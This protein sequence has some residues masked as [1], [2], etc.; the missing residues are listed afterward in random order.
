MPE[1]EGVVVVRGGAQGFVQEITAGRHH[2]V[3]DEPV[4]A[5]GTDRGPGPYDLILAALGSCMSM[6]IALY[7]RTKKWPLET[8][9]IRLTHS[10]TYAKDCT[11]CVVKD[12]T[13]LDHIETEVVLSGALTAEQQRRLM[14][15]AHKCPVHRT[16]R[17]EIDIREVS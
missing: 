17:S 12:D 15:I 9:V 10:R 3:A 11:D 7:A 2:L 13:L 5:G 16:L 8:V 4:A 14:E 1:A 6:T